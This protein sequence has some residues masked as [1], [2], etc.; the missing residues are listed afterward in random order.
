MRF[1]ILLAI[2]FFGGLFSYSGFGFLRISFRII[3]RFF[4]S[5]FTSPEEVVFQRAFSLFWGGR[6]IDISMDAPRTVA[7]FIKNC[8]GRSFGYKVA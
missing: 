4:T 2:C 3:F 5:I 7:F 6:I 8:V 1:E